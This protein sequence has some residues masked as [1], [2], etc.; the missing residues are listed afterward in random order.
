MIRLH[1]IAEGQTEEEF[2]NSILGEHLV[3]FDIVTDVHCITTNTKNKIRG[4]AVNYPVTT[5]W[6]STKY[7]LNKVGIAHPTNLFNSFNFSYHE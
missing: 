1:V 5:R 4:G 6:D 3:N 7:K 2:V